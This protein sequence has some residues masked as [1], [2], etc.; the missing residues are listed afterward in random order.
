MAVTARHGVEAT[1]F[2][3]RISAVRPDDRGG[4]RD[5]FAVVS[6]CSS[7]LRQDA[8]EAKRGIHSYYQTGIGV[9]W[10]L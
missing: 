3:F 6:A 9:L 1:A 2:A 8:R 10:L 5:W 7:V 4:E